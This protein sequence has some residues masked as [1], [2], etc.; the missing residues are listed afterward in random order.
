M[1]GARFQPKLRNGKGA[2][3]PSGAVFHALAENS[4][5][6]KEFKVRLQSWHAPM[7][8]AR[9]GVLPCFGDR[10]YF[11]EASTFFAS[12]ASFGSSWGDATARVSS[13]LASAFL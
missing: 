3:P 13:A 2:H 1:P 8:V 10:A 9:A 6:G 7:L 4:G 11:N 12:A 5:R